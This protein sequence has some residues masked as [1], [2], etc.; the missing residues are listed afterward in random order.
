[1]E[2]EKGRNNA[3]GLF[4][5]FKIPSDVQIRNLLDAVDPNHFSP[6]DRH[7]ERSEGD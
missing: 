2:R 6:A 3:A 5:V 1:M 4:G 7:G